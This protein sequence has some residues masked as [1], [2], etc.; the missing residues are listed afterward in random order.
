LKPSNVFGGLNMSVDGFFFLA[1][2]DP[3]FLPLPASII[4]YNKTITTILC[5][6]PQT[7]SLRVVKKE[8][9]F[10]VPLQ[11]KLTPSKIE[12]VT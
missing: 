3:N 8:Q 4:C 2:G 12:L 6:K 7:R 11:Q 1:K 9:E 10:V 5:L